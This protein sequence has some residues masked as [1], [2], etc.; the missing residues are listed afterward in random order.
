MTVAVIE[1]GDAGLE[2]EQGCVM[3]V[4]EAGYRAV[5]RKQLDVALPTDEDIDYQKLGKALGADLIID[6]G[7]A[8][9][10][11][12]RSNPSP[13]LI[14]THSSNVLAIAKLKGRADKSGEVGHKLC[15]ELLMQL[16]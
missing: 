11:R 2:A 4:L 10:T 14:S 3:A 1:F 13:R 6:G 5:E 16:P 9:G 7:I 15:A 8:R 12:H